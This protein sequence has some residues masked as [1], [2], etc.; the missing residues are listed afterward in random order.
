MHGRGVCGC[1]QAICN[2]RSGTE[3]GRN[4]FS[5][6]LGCLSDGLMVEEMVRLLPDSCFGE[7]LNDC[8]SFFVACCGGCL[9]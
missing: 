7:S 9:T 3:T 5:L 1:W 4:H 2:F 8:A 6:L